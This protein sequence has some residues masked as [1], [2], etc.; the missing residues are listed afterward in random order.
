MSTSQ[1]RVRFWGFAVWSLGFGLRGSGFSPGVCN[2]E[3]LDTWRVPFFSASILGLGQVQVG[4][5][6]FRDSGS[7]PS[8]LNPC[9][10]RN[11]KQQLMA[12]TGGQAASAC[13]NLLSTM[14]KGLWSLGLR[15]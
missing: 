13:P 12:C 8:F 9:V 7:P 3:I 10:S 2:A 14:F 1:S 11:P 4:G 5:S 6:G 15:A